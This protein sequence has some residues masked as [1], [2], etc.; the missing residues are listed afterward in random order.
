M[1]EEKEL[2]FEE[3][4][5]QLQKIIADLEDGEHSLEESLANYEQGMNLVNFNMKLLDQAELRV[6]ELLPSGEEAPFA[7]PM[8]SRS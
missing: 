8:D 3:A 2:T 6:Q 5:A 7:G 4:L 1:S